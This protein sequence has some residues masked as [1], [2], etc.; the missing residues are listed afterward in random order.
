MAHP[1]EGER[2]DLRDAAGGNEQCICAL[3]R[4]LQGFSALYN[5]SCKYLTSRHS[6][7]FQLLFSLQAMEIL[8]CLVPSLSVEAYLPRE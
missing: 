6:F 8:L 7:T 5:I 1:N 3:Q 4:L 2:L